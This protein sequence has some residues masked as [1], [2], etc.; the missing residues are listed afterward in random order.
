MPRLQ[1]IVACTLAV[2]PFGQP[3]LMASPQPLSTGPRLIKLTVSP[4]KIL[5]GRFSRGRVEISALA[6]KGGASVLLASSRTDV[7]LPSLS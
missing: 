3:G 1:T 5:A 6:P 4:T 2:L 7:S